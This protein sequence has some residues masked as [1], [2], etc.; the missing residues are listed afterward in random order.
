MATGKLIWGDNLE[1]AYEDVFAL[2]DEVATRIASSLANHIEDESVS[3]ALRKPPES[4]SAFDCV[5]RARQYDD[6]YDQLDVASAR[7]LFK[8]AG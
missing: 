1:R 8:R 5:L 3:S 7:A 2:E 4:M 6:S